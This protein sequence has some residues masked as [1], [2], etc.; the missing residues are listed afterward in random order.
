MSSVAWW[1]EGRGGGREE[2]GVREGEHEEGKR[3][4]V[5]V[6][7]W[8]RL[9]VRRPCVSR[10]V[11]FSLSLSSSLSLSPFVTGFLTPVEKIYPHFTSLLRDFTFPLARDCFEEWKLRLL[12]GRRVILDDLGFVHGTRPP[13]RPSN[14]WSSKSACVSFLFFVW[15]DAGWRDR[16]GEPS[17]RRPLVSPPAV[18]PTLSLQHPGGSSGGLLLGVPLW[19]V[20]GR[21]LIARNYIYFGLFLFGLDFLLFRSCSDH[22]GNDV[23]F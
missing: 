14:L 2:Q 10:S 3:R 6:E 23:D 11:S 21:R 20:Y 5:S 15:I 9:H 16:G 8:Q 1:G 17:P 18:P 4:P 19:A 7:Q 13:A 22:N 12:K